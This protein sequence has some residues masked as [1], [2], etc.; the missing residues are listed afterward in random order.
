MKLAVHPCEVRYAWIAMPLLLFLALLTPLALV[1]AG[2]IRAISRFGSGCFE[3]LPEN[4][5]EKC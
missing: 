2:V 4:L 3:R 5:V 1:A